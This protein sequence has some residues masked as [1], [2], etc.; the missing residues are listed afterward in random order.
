MMEYKQPEL[1]A[2]KTSARDEG[3]WSVS[4]SGS[5]ILGKRA[6]DPHGIEGWVGIAVAST[7]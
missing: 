4:L 5:L 6:H 2:F 7:L 3:E 1:N